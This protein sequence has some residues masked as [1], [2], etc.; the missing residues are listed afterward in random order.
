MS[1]CQIFKTCHLFRCMFICYYFDTPTLNELRT[2][3]T[4]TKRIL[5]Q[6]R[7]KSTFLFVAVGLVLR[8]TMARV[9]DDL[10]GLKK[11]SIRRRINCENLF[12]CSLCFTKPLIP[13]IPLLCWRTTAHSVC[14]GHMQKIGQYTHFWRQKRC[15]AEECNTCSASVSTSA[16]WHVT[17]ISNTAICTSLPRDPI[18]GWHI[19]FNSHNSQLWSY[20]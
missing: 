9:M 5:P 12:A 6:P 20:K 10:L 1:P 2:R 11:G 16:R 19:R 17:H 15:L 18:P 7:L 3:F 13:F 8:R 4:R 14:V